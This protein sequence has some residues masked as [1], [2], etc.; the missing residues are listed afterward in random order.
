MSYGSRSIKYQGEALT[1][2]QVRAWLHRTQLQHQGILDSECVTLYDHR[3]VVSLSG[4][5][6]MSLP[7][8][9]TRSPC[10]LILSTVCPQ[11]VSTT[12]QSL[13]GNGCQ[14]E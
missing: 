3:D 6:P 8:S 7:R 2:E 13:L 10:V 14:R 12:A 9:A 5:D 4:S 1:E 11:N